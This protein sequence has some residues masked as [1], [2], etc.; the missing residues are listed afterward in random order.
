M[1]SKS[2]A[3]A[4]LLM[5][6]LCAPAQVDEARRYFSL[7]TEGPVRAG[8]TVPVRVSAQGVDS[9]E[10]RLY[11]VVDPV[12]FFETLGDPHS[13]GPAARRR[14]KAITPIEKFAEWRRN[15]RAAMRDVVRLQFGAEQRH[16]IRAWMNKPE[17]VP[18][19]A[20]PSK[21]AA[22]EYAQAPLLNP[23]R[24]VRVWKQSVKAKTKWDSVTVPVKLDEKGL[25]LLEATDGQK[26]AYTILSVTDLALLTK[27][28]PGRALVRVVDRTTGAAVDGV[29]VRL[30]DAS[31]EEVA[32]EQ[33]TSPGRAFEWQ[34]KQGYPEGLL[35]TA[36][37]GAEFAVTTVDS[38]ALGGEREDLTGYVYTDRPVYRPG[39]PVHAKAVLRRP[40]VQGYELPGDNEAEIEITNPDDG[41]VLKKTV[42]L[43]SAGTVSADVTLPADAPLGY[44]PVRVS[45]GGGMA[46]G[47][48]QVEEYR[49]P[50]YE[51]R[52]RTDQSR[53]IQGDQVT[54]Q[55][56]AKY[57]Y[58]EPVT[59]AKV[60]WTIYRSRSWPPWF[61][62]E[63]EME[64]EGE[65]GDGIAYGSQQVDEGTG[66]LDSEGRLTI[67]VATA[68][69]KTDLR[70]G[71][72]VNVTDASGRE[73]SGAASVTATRGPFFVSV[74]PA[75]FIS[76]RGSQAK[77]VVQTRDYDGKPV[78]GVAF[79]VDVSKHE[80]K[81]PKQPVF[82]TL[83]GVTGPDGRGE[84]AF[85]APGGGVY[86]ARVRASAPGGITLDDDCLLWV[87]GEGFDLPDQ[88]RIQV[89]P[90]KKT[91]KA[92]ETA[93]ILVVTGGPA[94]VWVSA[95]ARGVLWQRWV[96]VKG[97][98]VTVE[99]KVESSWE[100]NVHIEAV[101]VRGDV[102]HRGSKQVKVPAAEKLINVDLA[103]GKS[104]Y[105]PGEPAVFQVKATDAH[106]KPVAAEFSLGVVD[107]SIYA[108]QRETV[109][110]IKDVFYGQQWNRVGTDSSLTFYFGGSAG[111]SRIQLAQEAGRAPVRYGQLKEERMAEPR[112]RKEFPDT[113]FWTASL[114]T[115]ANGMGEARFAFPDS[116]TTWRATARGVTADTKVGQAV[117][118]TLV[119]KNL[120]VSVATPRFFT[121]GDEA[122]LPVIV[123]SSLPAAANVKV[124]LEATG[125]EV[126]DGGAKQVRLEPKGEAVVD[127]LIR[128]KPGKQVTLL[129]QAL[130]GHESDALELKLP[131][132]PPGLEYV[133]SKTGVL[134]TQTSE[135]ASMSFDPRSVPH[136]RTLELEVAPSVAGTLFSALDYLVTYPYG[137]TEQTMSS[138][139]PNIVVAQAMKKLNLPGAIDK[140]ALDKKVQAGFERLAALQHDDG[141]WGWWES[142]ET[143]PFMTAYVAWGL[144]EAVEAGYTSHD[145][146][147]NRSDAALRKQFDKPSPKNKADVRAWQLHALARTGKA[148]KRDLDSVW[149]KR[150]ELTSLG[151]ALMGLASQAMKDERTQQIGLQLDVMAKR[152]GPYQW[153]PADRDLMLDFA[154]DASTEATAF[155]LKFMAADQNGA[156]QAAPA[157]R[158]L[159]S[160][161][162]RG[163][164]W[165]STKET[166]FAVLGLTEYLNRT[167][168]LEPNFT[169]RVTLN[170][171]EI[172]KRRFS[173]RD[174]FEKPVKVAMSGQETGQ[175]FELKVE[176]SGEGQLHW[177]AKTSMR[178]LT[179]D[180]VEPSNSDLRLRREYFKLTPVNEGGRIVH[181]LTPVSGEVKQGDLIACRLTVSGADH[182]YVLIEDPLPAGAEV[183]PRDDLYKIRGAPP[184]W[185]AGW[186][187]RQVRDSRVGFLESWLWK[188]GAEYMYLFRATTAG[189]IQAPPAR[190]EPMYQPEIFSSS[191]AEK[192]EVTRP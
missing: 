162:S 11:R 46:Y 4:A 6:A 15:V 184:W 121:E 2:I 108:V 135:Q 83:H 71:L 5:A 148:T 56:T 78:S 172:L 40:A 98:S 190:V 24:V 177:T 39:H 37:K 91:Y 58:G 186:A 76:A 35:V 74:L 115:G 30:Y 185:R 159:L 119:R 36:R 84:A 153:W 100:P 75:S 111:K 116:L 3:W 47:G 133:T 8:G 90:D 43:T 42:R 107:E 67:R 113:A 189:K 161:R 89:V 151:W 7:S 117:A 52:V 136:T 143:D 158:W 109:R 51:V 34:G 92:G 86:K 70:Y 128:V 169:A 141:G 33:V 32:G 60:T 10:F 138:F 45:I 170:G 19:K 150:S 104:T 77:L 118:R 120:I 25:Y 81:K 166:A 105:Q 65:G 125:V 31:R 155:A 57:Y 96:E 127:Y 164:R 28:E 18:A 72:Q 146:M 79:H 152:A 168:E 95:E 16:Q 23:Q 160:R 110:N 144:Q 93:R 62:Y 165:Q 103:A 174:V 132:E 69:A 145:H 149:E 129:A 140:K 137:C 192:F 1:K 180:V 179:G 124:S 82:A 154:R 44:Y 66:E 61:D 49:K 176:K 102:L 12:Q 87:E 80:W 156:A 48:F 178:L 114:M 147:R 171:R 55:V 97:S 106:G 20:P 68:G 38:W 183:I 173:S 27:A 123:R 63:E 188:R 182:R 122:V 187:R 175:G 26:Q 22:T 53:V 54:F 130:S 13:A 101:F 142:D 29:S 73:I 126:I 88:E 99:A 85:V 50:E 134:G 14:A 191:S 139:V 112:A 21:A 41:T 181:Q 94:H 157:A 64:G 131:V 163:S 9:L 167:G 59:N 17:E